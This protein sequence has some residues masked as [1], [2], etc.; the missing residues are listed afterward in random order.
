MGLRTLSFNKIWMG[1]ILSHGSLK[2]E[3]L[4]W[5]LL[6]KDG[7]KEEWSERYNI[8]G[9]EHGG[10]QPRNVGDYQSWKSQENNKLS[11]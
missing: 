5:L 1:P 4:S 10:H 7:T 6:E 9:F 3:K 8:A 2:V 11:P